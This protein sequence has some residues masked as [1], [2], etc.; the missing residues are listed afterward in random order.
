MQAMTFSDPPHRPQ[1]SSNTYWFLVR[2]FAGGTKEARSNAVARVVP[3]VVTYP[4][5]ITS[6]ATSVNILPTVTGTLID[7]LFLLK[8]GTL[9]MGLTLNPN[10]GAVTGTPTSGCDS[11]VAILMV[12]SNGTLADSTLIFTCGPVPVQALSDMRLLLL[13]VLLAGNGWVSQHSMKQKL[14]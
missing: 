14:G 11:A 6:K 10:T 4:T 9:P 13:V 7:P 12:E 5:T 8:S 3:V 2:A 1:V